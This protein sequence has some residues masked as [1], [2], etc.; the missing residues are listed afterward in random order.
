MNRCH[1][2]FFEFTKQHLLLREGTAAADANPFRLVS[3]R[4]AAQC[5]AACRVPAVRQLLYKNWFDLATKDAQHGFTKE[6]EEPTLLLYSRHQ[7]KY[8]SSLAFFI[9]H[10][11][12]SMLCSEVTFIILRYCMNRS[13]GESKDSSTPLTHVR[14]VPPPSRN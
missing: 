1:L 11:V 4:N 3:T 14:P 2:P 12:F 5:P 7:Q 8:V 6:T 10:C 13:S 9:R